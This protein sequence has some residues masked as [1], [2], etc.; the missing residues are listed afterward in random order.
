MIRTDDIEGAANYFRGKGL[1]VNGPVPKSRKTPDGRVIEWHLLYIGE[2][3]METWNF[4]T[5][6]SGM[7]VMS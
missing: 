7:K 2:T 4:R 1:Q 6:F 3:K 5:L